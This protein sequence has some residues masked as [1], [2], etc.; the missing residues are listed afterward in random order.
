MPLQ[1]ELTNIYIFFKQNRQLLCILKDPN[2][3]HPAQWQCH[4]ITC[5]STTKVYLISLYSLFMKHLKLDCYPCQYMLL[6]TPTDAFSTHSLFLY[7][8]A[9]YFQ[10]VVAF[11][12][13][14]NGAKC[15]IEE[16]CWRFQLSGHKKESPVLFQGSLS[17]KSGGETLK[18]QVVGDGK[19]C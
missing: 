12:Q 17:F 4:K 18:E 6:D 13:H 19:I 2:I 1:P 8:A 5:V 10:H 3:S 14:N 15:A 9:F 16:N 7:S 11:L